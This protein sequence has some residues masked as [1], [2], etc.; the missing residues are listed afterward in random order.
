V[1]R[2]GQLKKSF[3]LVTPFAQNL[4]FRQLCQSYVFPA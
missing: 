3:L 4:T 1:L 2:G